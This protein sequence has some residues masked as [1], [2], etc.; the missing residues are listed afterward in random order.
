MAD[1]GVRSIPELRQFGNN[2]NQASASLSNL[3][4]ILNSQMQQAFQ[5][6]N[7]QNAQAFVTEFDRSKAQI[8]KIAHDMQQFSSYISRYCEKLEESQNIRI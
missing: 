6:W 8:D 4:Q 2:L 7:D 5:G 1:V 3:F